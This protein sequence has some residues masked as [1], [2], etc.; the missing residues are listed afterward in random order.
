MFGIGLTRAFMLQI[1]NLEISDSC[2]ATKN[3][4]HWHWHALVISTSKFSRTQSG[5]Q[6]R[7]Q[8]VKGGLKVPRSPPAGS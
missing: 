4:F 8:M 1:S 3:D 7:E 5:G 6:S 2:F